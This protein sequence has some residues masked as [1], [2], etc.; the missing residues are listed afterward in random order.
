MH[1]RAI[2]M[3]WRLG[4]IV[5]AGFAAHV[6]VETGVIDDPLGDFD[7]GRAVDELAELCEAAFLRQHQVFIDRH[8]EDQR[9]LLEDAADPESES[10]AVGARAVALARDSTSRRC[11]DV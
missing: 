11:P 3:A 5:S 9:L 1:A 10:L 6:D 8:I 7:H 4:E 2:S